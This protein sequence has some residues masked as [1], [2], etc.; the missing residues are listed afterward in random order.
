M[1]M[2]KEIAEGKQ[3]SSVLADPRCKDLPPNA[4]AILAYL[5]RRREATDL[6]PSREEVRAGAGIGSTGTVQR[7]LLRLQQRGLV[8]LTPHTARGIRLAHGPGRD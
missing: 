3:A 1:T 6:P 7:W 2:R 4:R 8:H 5:E